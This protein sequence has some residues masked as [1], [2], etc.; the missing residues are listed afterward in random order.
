MES[1]IPLFMLVLFLCIVLLFIRDIGTIWGGIKYR[2]KY[3]EQIVSS[4]LNSL[5]AEYSLWNDIYLQQNGYSVQ[6]D[7]IVISVYGIFVIETKN[8]SGWIYGNDYSMQWEKN[9]YGHRY[10]FYNPL[11]QNHSHVKALAHLFNMSENQFVPIVVFL[12]RAKLKC[13]TKGTVIYV[14]KLKDEIFRYRTE[15]LSSSEVLRLSEVLNHAIGDDKNRNDYHLKN[16]HRS[17]EFR[18]DK[19]S[20]RIC[21]ECNGTLVVRS[22]KY[23]QF[24]G[25]SNYPR[26]RFTMPL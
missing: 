23:G 24:M 5:P 6:I 8:I 16:V 1:F 22:G 13:K 9:M 19:V 4:I 17:M 25:C 26:C 21:P 2:G 12:Q 10:S 3:G 11:K 20:N 15:V 14:N 18:N 7:H